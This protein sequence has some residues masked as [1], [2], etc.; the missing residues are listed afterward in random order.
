MKN[1]RE[2]MEMQYKGF[3]CACKKIRISQLAVV[4]SYHWS[5]PCAVKQHTYYIIS[6]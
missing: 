6:F 3:W 4:I 5:N 2:K 1:I